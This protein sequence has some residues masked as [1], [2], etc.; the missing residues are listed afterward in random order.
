MPGKAR[1]TG[2]ISG[3]GKSPGVGNVNPLFLSGIS[4]G[5]RSLMGYSHK[6]SDM[7]EDMCVCVCVCV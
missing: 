3:S 1:D 6:E 5:Q 7:T 2:S 4:L